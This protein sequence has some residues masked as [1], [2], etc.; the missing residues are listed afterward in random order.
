MR[1]VRASEVLYEGLSL[2]ELEEGDWAPAEEGWV[3]R[4]MPY[5]LENNNLLVH[6][7][8]VVDGFSVT[9]AAGVGEITHYKYEVVG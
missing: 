4:H 5:S 1:R 3:S 2:R 7:G 8:L 6:T 9:A